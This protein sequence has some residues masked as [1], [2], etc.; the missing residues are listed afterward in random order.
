[1]QIQRNPTRRVAIGS[2]AIG[3]G[4]PIAVQSM[5]A[6]KT[7]DVDATVGQVRALEAAGADVVR[8]AVDSKK[9]AE[10]LAEIRKQTSANLSVDLQENYRLAEL[11]APH[12]DKV[13]YNPGHLY[14]H[15]RTK[16][17]KEKVEYLVGVAKESDCAMR[18]GVNCGSVDPDKLAMYDP[19]DSITPMLESA[20]EHCDHL[21][22][23][24]FHR[25]CVSLKDSDPQKVIE[26]NKRFAERRPDVPLHLGVT[27]A[28]MPPDG[29]IKTRIAFEQLISR[30]I[31]DTIRVSLTVPNPRKPEEIAAGRGILEDIA[32]GRVRSVVDFG[33]NTLNIISCPS[34]SRVEN[35]A[36]V[37]LAEQVRDMTQY[38]KEHDVT[39][40][41]MGC[42]VN[43]PGETDDADLGLWCGP[44]FVNLKRGGEELGAFPYDEILGKLK[45]ELDALIATRVGA[46]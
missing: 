12:V 28:G 11:V 21:D 17:W 32:A 46:N 5:T 34:C 16:P 42:R 3:D 10:A 40:A 9:D 25:F 27:E 35:E 19:E 30:G 14:H 41:V 2:I 43:G 1:M 8:I 6:T 4:N 22:S 23:L 31:G 7:Q 26:V 37:E 36:F 15:E 33:L 13:R 39:I 24:D 44:N 20:L 45:H 29:I 38:A 18:I